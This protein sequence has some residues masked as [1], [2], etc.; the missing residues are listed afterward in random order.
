MI[1]SGYKT[2]KPTQLANIFHAREEEKISFSALRTYFACHA[3]VAIREAAERGQRKQGKK[4]KTLRR[5]QTGEL[6]R[7]TQLP[8]SSVRRALR[9]LERAGV[10]SFSESEIVI[11]KESLPGSEAWQEA[12]SCQR[13]AERPIPVPRAMLRFLSQSTSEIL[14]QVVCAYLV[15][16]LSLARRTGEIT[17]CGTV[18]AS[19]I[20]NVFDASHRAVKYAQAE[21]LRL[22]WITRDTQSHQLKLNRHGAY[23]TINLEW[24]E[25][26]LTLVEK[27]RTNDSQREDPVAPLVYRDKNVVPIA[28]PSQETAPDFAP[29][30]KDKETSN[31]DQNQET[32]ALAQKSAGCCKER[33]KNPALRN[34]QRVDLYRFDRLEV[35]YEQAVE[36]G[37]IKP[38]EASALNFI[39]A[40]V[41]A[42]EVGRDPPRVFVTL[43]RRKLWHHLTQAQEETARRA[44]NR[45]REVDPD[46]FR[47]RRNS[48]TVLRKAA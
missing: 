16:G 40:A 14:L 32:A 48:P 34:I 7:L 28:P 27:P 39:A 31:E 35:L 21:L 11:G 22:G 3:I 42:R 18:K 5:Y 20:A 19:W 30:K 9:E 43:L 26:A 23:F 6:S 37:W 4:P 8:D 33:R 29:P 47:I 44:L 36:A 41:R 12:L 45:F 25:P 17:A 15:R 13:S 10:L 24:R 38:C 1:R 46:R 2:I